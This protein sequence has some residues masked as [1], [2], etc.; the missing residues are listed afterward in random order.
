MRFSSLIIAGFLAFTSV[1]SA[2][3]AIE[4]INPN[5]RKPTPQQAQPRPQAAPPVFNAPRVQA[6]PMQQ[7]RP[8]HQPRPHVGGGGGF[9]PVPIPVP[10]YIDRPVYQQPYYAQEPRYYQQPQRYYDD[11][12]TY[13]PRRARNVCRTI[14]A[15]DRWGGRHYVKKCRPAR[16]YR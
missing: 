10:Q 5:F 13:R 16:R 4:S 12:P 7:H 8:Q 15:R 9:F 14:V 3:I 6:A 2:Q 1:A 11:E